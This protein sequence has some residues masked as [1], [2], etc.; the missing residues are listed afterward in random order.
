M[1]QAKLLQLD[2]TYLQH[3][4]QELQRDYD[5]KS[6]RMETERRGHL[7]LPG[8]DASIRNI[9]DQWYDMQHHLLLDVIDQEVHTRC[10]AKFSRLLLERFTQTICLIQVTFI[11]TKYDKKAS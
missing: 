7:Q 3:K 8:L 5:V 9:V 6:M 10:V 2:K 4:A 11:A 1:L